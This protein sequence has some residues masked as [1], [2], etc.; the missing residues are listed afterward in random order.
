MNLN[1]R[2]CSLRW[3]RLAHNGPIANDETPRKRDAR[4]FFRNLPKQ[5]F[6]LL[7]RARDD[8]RKYYH[9]H[10]KSGM[11]WY[12]DYKCPNG[13]T[14]HVALHIRRGDVNENSGKRWLN[15]SMIV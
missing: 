12:T 3:R 10:N 11:D 13:D 1:L 7:L 2:Y 9:M 15:D 4:H 14:K 8:V 6:D 5:G